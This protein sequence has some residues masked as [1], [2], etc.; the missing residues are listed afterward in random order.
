[1]QTHQPR[2]SL[3]PKFLYGFFIAFFM[4]LGA[5]FFQ[6]I[7]G[8]DPCPL[9]LFQRNI[10]LFT[11]IIFFIAAI[12]N[13]KGWT[14]RLYA[15]MTLSTTLS[16]IVFSARHT[17]LHIQVGTHT[18]DCG[19]PELALLMERLP[20]TVFIERAFNG[21]IDCIDTVTTFL[22]LPLPAWIFLIYSFLF[23]YSLL[24]LIRN[25]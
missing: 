4:A 14:R 3:R 23:G 13:P 12:H 19:G 2:S 11:S 20:L 7:V 21:T 8:I 5:F 16:G 25:K 17:W 15:F 10:A 18:S 9:C 22:H 1:M 6:Y 24:M